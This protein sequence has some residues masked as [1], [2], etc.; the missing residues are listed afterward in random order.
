LAL[1]SLTSGRRSVGVVRSRTKATEFFLTNG[2]YHVLGL[3]YI[4]Q[5]LAI[6]ILNFYSENLFFD[7][8][9]NTI[10]FSSGLFYIHQDLAI[11]VLNVYSKILFFDLTE[12][13]V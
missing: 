8:M 11:A 3:F 6:A 1:T 12:N 7:L 13:A 2:K 4:Q 9:E 10:A 5:H